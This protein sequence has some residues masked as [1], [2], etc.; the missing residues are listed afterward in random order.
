MVESK[1]PP[2]IAL[3]GVGGTIAMVRSEHSG[4]MPALDATALLDAVPGLDSVVRP[5]PIN[6]KNVPSP[7]LGLEDLP[8]IAAGITAAFADG[9]VGVVVSQ[10]TDTIDEIAF[11][12]HLLQAWPAPVVVTG[13]LRHP[14]QAGAD[15]P[16]NILDAMRVAAHPAAKDRGVMVVLNAT[17]HAADRVI[18]RH[19]SRPDAFF[20]PRGALGEIIEDAVY[21]EALADRRGAGAAAGCQQPAPVALLPAALGDDGRLI[22]HLQGAGYRG[23]VLDGMGGGHLHPTMADRLEQLGPDFPVIIASRTG[24]GRTL[25]QT[26]GYP[27]AEI[28]LAARGVIRAGSLTG[29]KARIALSLLIGNGA[30]RTAVRG[31]FE[32]FG[33]G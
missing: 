29:L 31:F 13:A 3:L 11:G 4:V 2:E 7:H 8:D 28:D 27:G 30:E 25:R 1:N 20:S 23:L 15:G 10:G 21:F 18:K 5:R 6:L 17:I 12:L 14:S 33:G 26:Y 9:C 19:V 24:S 16:A 22:D 32:Q